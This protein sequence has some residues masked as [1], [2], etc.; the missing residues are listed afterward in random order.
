LVRF[1]HPDGRYIERSTKTESCQ[2]ALRVAED[3]IRLE[4]TTKPVTSETP[5]PVRALKWKDAIL[6]LQLHMRMA[7]LSE[8]TIQQYCITV[9]LLQAHAT[10]TVGPDQVSPDIA[11]RFLATRLASGAAIRTVESNR[12]TLSAVYSK[13]WRARCGL[14]DQDPF[15]RTLTS[16]TSNA[17]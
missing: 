10:E 9:R 3:L 2:V 11:C 14:L 5:P 6:L 17:I 16:K 8:V 7:G 15:H 1:R 4:F 13:W 12:M